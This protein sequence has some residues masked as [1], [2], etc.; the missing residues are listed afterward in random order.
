VTHGERYVE[1]LTFGKPDRFP[2]WFMFGLM[3]GVRDRWVSE[4]MPGS[5]KEEH[6]P[7][8]FGFDPEP[9]GIHVNTGM[10]PAPVWR[11]V[12]DTDEH[13]IAASDLGDKV[14]RVK[15]ASTLDHA[16]EYP[17]KTRED[18]EAI[19]DRFTYSPDRFA[20]DWLECCYG[21]REQ[22]MAIAA[23]GGGGYGFPRNLM[24][25]LGLCLAYYEQ[26][27][28]VHDIINTQTELLVAVSE[29]ILS[30][31]EVDV[32]N[33]WEDMAHKD[34]SMISPK[35]FREFSTPH[36]RRIIELYRSHGTRIFNVDTDGNVG[37]LIPLMLEAGVTAMLPFEVQAGNDITQVRKQYGQRLA[38]IGG[39]NKLALTRDKRVID[40]E[41][42]SKLP[43]MVQTGG[44]IAGLD[45]RVVVETSYGNFSY[46]AERIREYLTCTH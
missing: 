46:F 41:L 4:G 37:G 44:Y 8:H 25:D 7:F 28:L 17:V 9:V 27:D 36:Y 31:A 35:T 45:H 30:R 39:I 32:V 29:E 1:A 20:S 6:I 33:F 18:W 3:P 13:R 38:I 2:H 26:P 24:G 11:V 43:P 40:R 19:K 10:I 16:L 15:W 34:G 22:G 23:P 14:M 42:E 21:A 12:E 5:V